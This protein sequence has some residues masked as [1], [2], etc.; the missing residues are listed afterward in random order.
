MNAYEISFSEA[1]TLASLNFVDIT[2][3]YKWKSRHNLLFKQ[4]IYY[5]LILL[6]LSYEFVLEIILLIFTYNIY[7]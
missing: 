3:S 7:Y 2:S 4:P 1:K 6:S 5:L